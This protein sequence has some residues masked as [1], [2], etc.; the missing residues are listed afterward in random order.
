[1]S[2][3]ISKDELVQFLRD[4]NIEA[5]NAAR[6]YDEEGFLDL[7][8]IDLNDL[9]LFGFNLSRVD[10][11]GSDLSNSEIENPFGRITVMLNAWL[12]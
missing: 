3:L 9:K 2:E 4:G 7:S 5:F 12:P 6:P 8:E 1:M 11:S 10:L